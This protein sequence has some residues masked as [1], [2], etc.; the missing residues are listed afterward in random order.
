MRGRTRCR[1][2]KRVRPPLVEDL[3]S[4]RLNPL[5][6]A[7]NLLIPD[8]KMDHMTHH[9]H[10]QAAVSHGGHKMPESHGSHDPH[11]GHSVAMFRDKFWLSFALTIPDCAARQRGELPRVPKA[12]SGGRR[13]GSH[14]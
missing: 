9:G 2:P 11:A 10:G 13:A 3:N 14:G 4:A 5:R 6:A 12:F 7:V 8:F 1:R